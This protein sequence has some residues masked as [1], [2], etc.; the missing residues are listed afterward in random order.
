M[1][2]VMKKELERICNVALEKQGYSKE[3]AARI[4]EVLIAT[5]MFGIHSHGTKNLYMYI[6]KMKQGG[7]DIKANPE[8][9]V[10]GPA[11]AVLDAKDCI[12]MKGTRIAI[13]KA[14]ELAKKTGV[15]YVGVKNSCHFGA[16]TFY[17][18][19][20]A[21]QGMFGMIMSNVDPNMAVPGGKGMTLGNNPI[22]Y[23]FPRK[24]QHPI[25]FD[26]ALSVVAALKINKAKM[27]HQEIP[28]SWMVDPDGIPTKNPQYYQEGGALLPMGGHKGYGFSLLVDAL[29]GF[30]TSGNTCKDIES[31]CF[32]LPNKNRVSH[33]IICIDI[34]KVNP[35]GHFED[36]EEDYLQYILNSP[37]AKGTDHLMV[38]GQREWEKYDKDEA[39]GV[40]IP[41]DVADSL[42]KLAD[43]INEKIDWR[44]IDE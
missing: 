8:F 4:S 39:N 21:K 20:M 12:G 30:M 40:R 3:D 1:K 16:G 10:E 5:D 18:A 37:K 43:S 6:E 34:S 15:A 36:I 31:W 41:E 19:E 22:A 27:Y 35:D 9:I 17:V 32:N 25:T 29:S 13:N 28:D 7:I 23:A 44:D 2:L 38:P 24:G 11:F 42:L 33:A 14:V 26:I